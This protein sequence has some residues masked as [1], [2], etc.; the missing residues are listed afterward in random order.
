MARS[1]LLL[2]AL[3]FSFLSLHGVGQAEESW[4]VDGIQFGRLST[5]GFGAGC[6]CQLAS[7]PACQKP[8]EWDVERLPPVTDSLGSDI[9]AEPEAD[10]EAELIPDNF[11]LISDSYGATPG[12]RSA[13]P[14]MIG[15]FFGAAY[16]MT[17][18]SLGPQATDVNVPV[19]GGDRRFKLADG[20]NPVPVDRYFVNY[21]RFQNALL[22]VDGQSA[23]LN[24]VVFGLE[25][26]FHDGRCSFEVRVPFAN[27][28]NAVQQATLPVTGNNPNNVA[29]EFGNIAFALKALLYEGPS[30][31]WS[32][33]LGM[34]IP[35]A[36]DSTV[37]DGFGSVVATVENNAFYVQPF[38]GMLWTPNERTFAQFMTQ[39]DFDTTG[40]RVRIL[41][42]A[43]GPS[44]PA[45]A[46]EGV[47]Q[48]QTLLFLDAS[49]GYWLYRDLWSGRHITGIAPIIELHYSGTLGGTDVVSTNTMSP[50]TLGDRFVNSAGG[51]DVLNITGGLRLEIH[52]D[53]YFTCAAVAPLRDGRD[54]LFDVEVALQ[55]V[56]LY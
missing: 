34:V 31:T 42:L 45:S 49:F 2:A 22:T 33:G 27:G 13:A 40:N 56:G 23:N 8:D 21:N 20:Y 9:T 54:K 11:D 46:T 15:D 30:V 52:G 38:C 41:D 36:E 44:P 29:T 17:F 25:K 48:D 10:V 16:T 7:C 43:P 37:F 53:S 35:S 28:L 55:Y 18:P 39:L 50:T 32:A 26:T 19:G 6:D 1:R 51:F 5:V 3:L 47:I 12:S 4:V 24:R 14:A